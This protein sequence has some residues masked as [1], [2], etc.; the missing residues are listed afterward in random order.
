MNEFAEFVAT[1]GDTVDLTDPAQLADAW[2]AWASLFDPD[3]VEPEPAAFVALATQHASGIETPSISRPSPLSQWRFRGTLRHYQADVLERVPVV[4]GEPLHIV[5]PPGSGKTV[6]GLLLAARHGRRAVVLAPTTTIRAQWVAEAEKLDGSAGAVSEDPAVIGDLTALTYQALSVLETANPLDELASEEWCA[7]LVSGGRTEADARAWIAELRDANRSAYRAGI[8]RRSRNLR[9][10]LAREDPEVLATALHPNARAL[11]DRLVAH[12]VETIL[13]DECHHLLDH[14]ALVVAYLAGRI[15]ASGGVPLLIGLTATLPSTDDKEQYDNY[16]GLLGEV[17]YEV[18]TPAVVKEGNL[19]PYRDIVW[20]TEPDAREL[21]FLKHHERELAELVR[22]LLSGPDGIGFL[23]STLQPTETRSGSATNA[24]SSPAMRLAAAFEADFAF[25]EASSRMLALVAPEHPLVDLL[26]EAARAGP[27][28]E[29]SIRV[30]AR[31]ALDRVLPVEARAPEWERVKRTVVDFGY[32]LTDRGIR[33]GRNA[34]DTVLASSTSKDDA[35]CEIVRLELARSAGVEVK[36]VI[37]TDFAVHGN[38]RGGRASNSGALRLFDRVVSDT[39]LAALRP[40]LVT[41]RHLRIAERDAAVLLPE[42]SQRLGLGDLD[43]APVD[44]SPGVSEVAVRGA[45]SAAVVGAVSDLVTEGVVRIIV[46]TRGLLGEGWDCPAVNTLIDLTAVATSSATQQL[47]GRTLRLDPA[48]PRKVA[49]NWTVT[50][51]VPPTV[52]ITEQPDVRRMLRKHGR[53]WGLQREGGGVVVRGW[54]VALTF[55]QLIMLSK[56]EGKDRTQSVRALNSSVLDALPTRDETYREWRVGEPYADREQASATVTSR[57]A[58]PFRTGIALEVVLMALIGTVGGVV[59]VVLPRI[60]PIIGS[61]PVVGIAVLAL[62]T[63]GAIVLAWPLVRQV[64]LSLRQW[65]NAPE[66]YRGIVMALVKTLHSS[67]K[68]AAYGHGDI[69]VTVVKDGDLAVSV[70]AGLVAGPLE[71]Q[72]LIAE[73]VRELFAPVRSPRFLLQV[74]RGAPPKSKNPAVALAMG[75]AGLFT[76]RDRYLQV[77][78]VIGRRRADALA[79]ADA[80][81]REVGAC[82]LHEL[83]SPAKLALLVEARRRASDA[84]APPQSRETWS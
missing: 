71:H 36:A 57:T 31:F 27:D 15:R 63:G 48:W 45:S 53:V 10:R 20:F 78:A 83:D 39:D 76:R 50:T 62:I 3:A 64:R 35:A 32:T 70:E 19:A 17:D 54:S 81:R 37:V 74:N 12:G 4:A 72:R 80:W 38:R 13:L 79:F 23:V 1:R 84:P 33:R 40:V 34:I 28:T 77:P 73:S 6:L 30:L 52:K 8:A 44:G 58:N 24:A 60:A 67:G 56:I 66:V 5:A 47:R 51:V 42:L 7:E 22:E 41:A 9:R 43:A 55:A 18:P 29:Q 65:V 68:I 21:D 26:P 69:A 75:I 25:A 49:H 14:W 46:G 59:G 61:S 11:V 2:R 16:S 82:T